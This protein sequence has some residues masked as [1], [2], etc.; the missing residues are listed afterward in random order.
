MSDLHTGEC[1]H[2]R[3]FIAGP[4]IHTVGGVHPLTKD[5]VI[6]LNRATFQVRVKKDVRYFCTFLFFLITCHHLESLV[7]RF[8]L[9]ESQPTKESLTP[10]ECFSQSEDL[11]ANGECN[12]AHIVFA[13]S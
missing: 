8:L 10:E 11:N 3:Y 5:S 12:P 7:C 4:S 13:K 9:K 2:G 6:C 1:I